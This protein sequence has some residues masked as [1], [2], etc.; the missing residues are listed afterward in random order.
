MIVDTRGTL[1]KQELEQLK[2]REK[3]SFWDWLPKYFRL[4]KKTSAIAGLYSTELVPYLKPIA[5][6]LDTRNRKIKLVVAPKATQ[7]GF[8]E[9]A[10]AFLLYRQLSAGSAPQLFVLADEAT[11]IY[12]N[13]Q[14][15][16][17]AIESCSAFQNVTIKSTQEQIKFSN[18]SNIFFGHAS[19]TA[20]LASKSVRD[21]VLDEL[22]KPGWSLKTAE[23]DT[24][25]LAKLRTTSYPH[26]KKIFAFSTVTEE[27]DNLDRLSEQFD[28]KHHLQAQC[29]SCKQWQ[30]LFFFK[31]NKFKT[32]DGRE[33]EGGYVWFDETLKTKAA[34]AKSARY[35]CAH[36][37]E[38]WTNSQKN[39]AIANMRAI[40]DADDSE[41]EEV[42]I[43]RAWRI[44]S[45]RQIGDLSELVKGFLDSKDDY[46]KYKAWFNAALAEHWK[47]PVE[48]IDVKLF[49]NCQ[50]DKPLGHVPHDTKALI[51]GV[52]TQKRGWWYTVRAITDYD[53]FKVEHGF[54][55]TEEQLTEI[56]FRKTWQSEDG[57]FF[58]I[59]R[60]GIDTGGE[61]KE[62]DSSSEIQSDFEGVDEI[63]STKWAY[64]YYLKN[65]GRGVQIFLTKGSSKDLPTL[66]R[67]SK[68]LMKFPNGKPIRNGLQILFIDTNKAKDNFFWRIWQTGQ[69]NP[70]EPAW[71]SREVKENAEYFQHLQ[72]EEKRKNK[73][74]V[75]RW[76]AIKARND[77]LD[78]ECI[79]LAISSREVGSVQLLK[80]AFTCSQNRDSS[81]K[82]K[83]TKKVVKKQQ[84]NKSPFSGGSLF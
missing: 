50:I 57:R 19:S 61:R 5:D 64:K 54:I 1:T 16:Q 72:A 56:I 39:K 44:H 49:E 55:E 83:K 84:K 28:V 79:I 62:L 8:T 4:T 29:Q 73:K 13:E 10:I 63:T 6:F 59:Y 41:L 52:D 74:G 32:E 51:M 48:K 69:E 76:T 22:T 25:E 82:L 78:T 80:K 43:D 40:A 12:V 35:V 33:I 77:L 15:V 14:R 46:K 2:P 3:I 34:R 18:G 58:P 7:I 20:N 11:S 47:E 42:F 70:I 38:L 30:K 67:F 60:V 23:G 68:P 65:R 36:C 21:L 27:G 9:F 66:T 81:E 24:L 26:N 31:G 45:P 53:S 17:S 71:V 75:A 37:G